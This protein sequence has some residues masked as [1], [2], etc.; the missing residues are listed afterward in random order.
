MVIT[1]GSFSGMEA[2][3]K[4][5]SFSRTIRTASSRMVRFRRPKKSIFS[6]PNSSSVVIMYWVT[7][8]PSL[9]AKGT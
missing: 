2:K 1:S 5:G 3:V 9:V 6:R 4:S 7:G 8:R